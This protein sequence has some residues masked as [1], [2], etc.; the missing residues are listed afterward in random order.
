MSWGI[1]Y[2]RSGKDTVI[3]SNPMETVARALNIV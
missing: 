3:K 2:K 1:K